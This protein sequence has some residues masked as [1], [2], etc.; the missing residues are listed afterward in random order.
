M[1]LDK[2]TLETLRIDRNRPPAKSSRKG[3]LVGV[4]LLAILFT[5]YRISQNRG[6][7]VK[8]AVARE[9]A[10]GSRQTVLNAS[11]YVTARRQA[12]VSS[13]VTGKVVEVLIEEGFKVEA[14][15]VLARLDDLNTAANLRLAQAQQAAAESALDELKVRLEEAGREWQRIS[16]LATNRIS[17]ASDRD[18]SQADFQAKK[19]Q[20]ARQE[21]EVTVAKRQVELLKQEVED[22][23]IRAPFSGIV[24]SKNAQPGEMISPISAGGG[25]TRTGICTI[26]DMAS[27]EVEVDVN[28]SFI[29]RVKAGQA[30]TSTLDAYPEWHIPSKVIAIIP[31]ADRQKATVKVRIGFNQLDPRILPDMGVKVEFKAEAGAPATGGILTPKSAIRQLDGQATVFVLKNGKVEARPVTVGDTREQEVLVTAGLHAGDKV[32]IEGPE[33]LKPGTQA[34]EN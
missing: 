30:V 14:G 26:V 23:V 1:S 10:G 6:I 9:A 12:T 15:Q 28:E 22:L 25:F 31:T 27:L 34:R 8:T 21:M 32:V 16:E 24:I 7:T 18:H 5:G 2:A 33:S 4:L 19:A 17:S 29:G 3:L 13:K 11:G 20:L